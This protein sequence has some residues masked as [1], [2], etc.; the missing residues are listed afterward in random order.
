M[1]PRCREDPRRTGSP[2]GRTRRTTLLHRCRRWQSRREAMLK[3]PRLSKCVCV[4]V[5]VCVCACTCVCVCVCVCVFVHVC[6]SSQKTTTAQSNAF[7]QVKHV[8]QSQHLNT[9]KARITV[10][11]PNMRSLERA[12]ERQKQQAEFRYKTTNAMNRMCGR[13][14]RACTHLQYS[15][16]SEQPP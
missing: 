16:T 8:L 13:G 5:C 4:C 12:C 7:H 14:T 10:R 2:L 6:I 15:Q 3:G 1:S 11:R 9:I